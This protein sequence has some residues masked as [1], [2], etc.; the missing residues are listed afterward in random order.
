MKRKTKI[1]KRD[2]KED[3]LT[4]I[5][6]LVLFIILVFYIPDLWKNPKVQLALWD[7]SASDNLEANFTSIEGKEY[8]F[9][10]GSLQSKCAHLESKNHCPKEVVTSDQ[11]AY[12]NNK[13]FFTPNLTLFRMR[14]MNATFKL[15]DVQLISFLKKN[16]E[17]ALAVRLNDYIV[18]KRH[19]CSQKIFN[20]TTCAIQWTKK[21]K[22]QNITKGRDDFFV[23]ITRFDIQIMNSSIEAQVEG[24]ISGNLANPFTELRV[25]SYYV[26]INVLVKQENITRIPENKDYAFVASTSVPIKNILTATTPGGA[27]VDDKNINYTAEK[28][29]YAFLILVKGQNYFYAK[30]KIVTNDNTIVEKTYS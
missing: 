16:E 2:D 30:E 9:I 4:K 13:S 20:D 25:Y 8:V 10:E 22:I 21:F 11:P 15:N 24:K 5:L 29:S 7:I 27:P 19:I 12:F 1:K 6:I 18:S 23:N 17:R 14:D 3:T 28:T 26:N